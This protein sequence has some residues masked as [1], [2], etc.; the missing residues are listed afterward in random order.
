MCAGGL[1]ISDF[2]YQGFTHC[3]HSLHV[4][5]SLPF[6]LLLLCSFLP[7]LAPLHYRSASRA[8]PLFLLPSHAMPI[9]PLLAFTSLSSPPYSCHSLFI[10]SNYLSPPRS[11]FFLLSFSFHGLPGL[12]FSPSRLPSASLAISSVGP[13]SLFSCST[14]F[15]SSSSVTPSS[16]L[17][18]RYSSLPS[19]NPS[20]LRHSSLSPPSGH[21]YS[22]HLH[23]TPHPLDF[24]SLVLAL[25]FLLF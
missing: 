17:R 10:P 5:S 20:L 25:V 22:S 23:H 1:R 24:L 9:S 19:I 3:T 14:V 11:S 21:S 12:S 15:L 8:L 2:G 6:L 13:F 16:S 4:P 18:L 7:M